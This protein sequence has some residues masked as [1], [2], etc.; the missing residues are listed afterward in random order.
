MLMVHLKS[1]SIKSNVRHVI[2]AWYEHVI[3]KIP[4]SVAFVASSI[5]FYTLLC[6]M[7]I[8]A[9]EQKYPIDCPNYKHTLSCCKEK[10][11]THFAFSGYIRALIQEHRFLERLLTTQWT[12]IR[13]D[14]LLCIS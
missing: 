9:H 5:Q 13:R 7:L 14:K 8:E 10:K 2:T 11:K 1:S 4:A 12:F 3:N 6:N